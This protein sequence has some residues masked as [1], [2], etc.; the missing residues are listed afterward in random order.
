MA[1]PPY[2]SIAVANFFIEK[3]VQSDNRVTP[4]KLIKL[5]YLAHGWHSGYYGTELLNEEIQAWK[6]GPVMPKLYHAIKGYGGREI[7]GLLSEIRFSLNDT[8]LE[9]PRVED[10]A[11]RKFLTSIWD[12]YKT[13]SAITLSALTHSDGSPWHRVWW[14]GPDYRHGDAKIP[15]SVIR[16]Y[17]RLKITQQ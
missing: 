12:H 8:S 9:V 13:Q 2:S 6:Y 10:V 17:Y 14:L 3:G 11:T 15:E 5:V 7:S 16:E 4:M 1:A